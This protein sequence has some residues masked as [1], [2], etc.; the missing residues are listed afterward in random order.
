MTI[1]QVRFEVINNKINIERRS[2]MP[3]YYKIVFE[4]HEDLRKIIEL[5]K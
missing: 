5:L 1:S 2:L 3:K 4:I